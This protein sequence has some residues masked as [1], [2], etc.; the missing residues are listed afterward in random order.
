MAESCNKLK[1]TVLPPSFDSDNPP[2]M[3]LTAPSGP[4]VGQVPSDVVGTDWI[5][6]PCNP[7]ARYRYTDE[8]RIEVE[9]E[10]V[11]KMPEWPTAVDDFRELIEVAADAN[12]ISRAL[13]AGLVATE[14]GG[15]AAVQ[16]A[17]GR[18]GLTQIPA[19]LA[20]VVA[21]PNF[22]VDTTPVPLEDYQILQPSWN[23]FH[24]AKLLAHYLET[25][26]N[27]LVAALAMYDHGQVLCDANP[28]CPTNRWGVWTECDY[29]DQ[30][31]GFTNLAVDV[32]YF[33]PRQVDLG[34]GD[35]QAAEPS[36]SSSLGTYLAFG[37]LG[38]GVAWIAGSIVTDK[39]RK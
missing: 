13:L 37:V 22:P 1:T 38:A 36:E 12:G 6:S 5:A 39:R 28:A 19:Q 21:N 35:G 7:Q 3:S 10:G 9:S 24:G 11:L 15:V 8:G 20:A 30:V 16:S 31:V 26:D 17:T 18:L 27:N 29:V 14:S 2:D 25:K 23:L 34:A 33:G 4:P 32:G